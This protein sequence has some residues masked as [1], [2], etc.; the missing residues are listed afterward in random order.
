VA[1]GYSPLDAAIAKF[2]GFGT[3]GAPSITQGNNPGAVQVGSLTSPWSTGTNPNGTSSFGSLADGLAALH[4]VEQSI[5]NTG[6]QTPQSFVNAYEGGVDVPAYAASIASDL[7]IG[8][9]SPIPATATGAA[10]GS[11]AGSTPNAL[12]PALPNALPPALPGS[13]S[14]P[15]TANK[16]TGSWFDWFKGLPSFA[17]VAAFIVGAGL[18]IGGV[19]FL[20]PV[21]QAVQTTVSTA[22]KGAA[23]F[24]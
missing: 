11:P 13:G 14:T 22:K 16:A 15:G 6:T 1:T 8:V 3:A 9:N 17:Q 18:I 23:L 12:P 20:R 24:I 2:E 5:F 7:G 4:N 19:F 10:A 21:Q